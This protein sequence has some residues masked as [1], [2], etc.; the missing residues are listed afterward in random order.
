MSIIFNQFRPYRV[1]TIFIL[2]KLISYDSSDKNHVFK[3]KY[4]QTIDMNVQDIGNIKAMFIICIIRIKM[5]TLII[6]YIHYTLITFILIYEIQFQQITTRVKTRGFSFNCYLSSKLNNKE[7][8]NIQ[9]DNT[10]DNTI[11]QRYILY[12][13]NLLDK[14]SILINLQCPIKQTLDS[15][16]KNH[17]GVQ[18]TI[19][20][21]CIP[22]L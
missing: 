10:P 22:I 7:K 13:R 1:Y 6:S 3:P 11:Y 4:K 5:Y 21:Q 20:I 2:F 15:H 16:I 8:I 18:R 19:C 9:L 14:W 12:Y 17:Y